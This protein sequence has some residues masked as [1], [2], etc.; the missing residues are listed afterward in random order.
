LVFCPLLIDNSKNKEACIKGWFVFQKKGQKDNWIDVKTLDLNKLKK[1]EWIKLELKAEE[2]LKLLEYTSYCREIYKKY[3]IAYGL[4]EFIITDKNVGEIVENILKFPNK[5]LLIEVLQNLNEEDSK[6][7]Y[8][9][10]NISQLNNVICLWD[11]NKNNNNEIFWR[12]TF[13]DYSWLISQ[14][15]ACPYLI[16]GDEYFYGGKKGNNKGG[17]YGDF[18]YQNK[19][20]GN[21]AFIEIKTPTT[22]IVSSQ[23]R[24]DN[25]EDHNTVY[26]FSNDLTGGIVQVLNQ[27][28]VFQQKQDSLEENKISILDSKCILIIGKVNDLTLGQK[29]SFDLFRNNIKDVAIITYDELFERI[30]ILKYIFTNHA[31]RNF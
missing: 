28:K 13:K 18:L 23:Y 1:G 5:Q 11:Q 30:K 4:S 21:V 25:D 17:V 29:K 20:T 14:I 3:G 6:N 10:L 16:I 12:Q 9:L 27:R 26:A 15:F 22:K 19:L 31:L 24:G 7:L 8:T 2:V